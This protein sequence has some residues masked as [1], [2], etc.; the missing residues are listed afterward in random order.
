MDF[1]PAADLTPALRA[2]TIDSDKPYRFSIPGSW[3]KQRVANILSGNY[4]QPRC[5]EPTTEVIFTDSKEGKA[6]V[7]R[8]D[9]FSWALGWDGMGR[10]VSEVYGLW[11]MACRGCL[12]VS[13]GVL[14][15]TLFIT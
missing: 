7:L 10:F 9:V 2:G 13:L 4:C 15:I 14:S 8:T 5:D 12:F 1:V 6:Q 11:S 3:R